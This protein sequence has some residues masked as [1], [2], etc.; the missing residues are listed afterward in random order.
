MENFEGYSPENMKWQ[1]FKQSP[2]P[3]PAAEI[4]LMYFRYYMECA[5]NLID[6]HK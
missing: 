6:A 1:Y 5:T 3:K 2:G 4:L